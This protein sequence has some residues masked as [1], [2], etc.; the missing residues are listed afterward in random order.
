MY[1][2]E[3]VSNYDKKNLTWSIWKRGKQG[4]YLSPHSFLDFNRPKGNSNLTAKKS[5]TPQKQVQ[6]ILLY[7]KKN[8]CMVDSEWQTMICM[9]FLLGYPRHSMM[10]QPGYI[11]K[12]VTICLASWKNGPLCLIVK[13]LTC[14]AELADNNCDANVNSYIS[15]SFSP[16][17]LTYC[18]PKIHKHEKLTLQAN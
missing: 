13:L 10:I 17:P 7:W 6:S 5:E 3:T 16:L 12:T 18:E 8:G 1:L 9:F 11:S 4:N 14:V 15:V 2:P